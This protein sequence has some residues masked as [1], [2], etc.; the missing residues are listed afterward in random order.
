MRLPSTWHTVDFTPCPDTPVVGYFGK[1]GDYEVAW[2]KLASNGEWCMCDADGSRAQ[3]APHPTFWCY[4][5][6]LHLVDEADKK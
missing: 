3:I 4:A 5:P 2:M 6:A 1:A